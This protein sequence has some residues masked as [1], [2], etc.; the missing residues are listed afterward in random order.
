MARIWYAC[1]S[2]LGNQGVGQKATKCCL[3]EYCETPPPF[4][5]QQLLDSLVLITLLKTRNQKKH[6]PNK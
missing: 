4:L 1:H 3:V 5:F 2:G 6:E